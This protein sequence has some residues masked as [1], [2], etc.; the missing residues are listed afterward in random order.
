MTVSYKYD[1]D[2]EF[3]ECP[4]GYGSIVDSV[5]AGSAASNSNVRNYFALATN[6]DLTLD[7]IPGGSVEFQP[8]TSS[9]NVPTTAPSG[10][11][12]GLSF[13]DAV[14]QG[15]TSYADFFANSNSVNHGLNKRLFVRM[16][17]TSVTTEPDTDRLIHIEGVINWANVV[18]WWLLP[19]DTLSQAEYDDY[20][21]L[22]NNEVY[23]YTVNFAENQNAFNQAH[24]IHF[25]YEN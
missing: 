6:D 9:S 4:L 12:G 16:T 7:S 3:V 13:S 17:T 19:K 8:D 1:N 2:V 20:I 15:N 14:K 5:K 18:C 24:N 21:Y 11:P 10:Y 25:F 22:F 23:G